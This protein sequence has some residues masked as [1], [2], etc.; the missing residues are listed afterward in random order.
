MKWRRARINL[1]LETNVNPFP[2]DAD[3]EA[4]Q[5][6][7]NDGSDMSKPMLINF[8]VAAPNE[9]TAKALADAAYK[10]GYQVSIYFSP[11]CSLPWTC[12]CS[13]Q[14]LATYEGVTAVQKELAELSVPFGGHCDGWGTF[15]NNPHCQ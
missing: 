11:E 1:E 4:L 9:A 6:V 15:G 13:T 5:R 7:A 8:Q 2:N 3:G 12:E 10:N 14:M